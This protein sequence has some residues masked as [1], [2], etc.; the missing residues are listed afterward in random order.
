MKH[1]LLILSTLISLNLSA[2]DSNY[3]R[4]DPHH[5]PF[6]ESINQFLTPVF[7]EGR[8]QI[9]KL[10]P[11]QHYLDIPNA[12]RKH[13][14]V[15][16]NGDWKVI[17]PA[18]LTNSQEPD[19]KILHMISKINK[20]YINQHLETIIKK[21]SRRSGAPGNQEIVTYIENHLK[22]HSFQ[23]TKN[24]FSPGLCNIY[25]IIPGEIDEYVLIEA[26]LDSVGHAN[27]GADDNASG[28]ASLLEL[29]RLLSDKSYK[30]GLIIFA[31]NGEESGLL[32]SK[33]FVKKAATSGL[34]SK[35]KFVINMDMIAY[36]KNKIVDIE[37]DKRFE[38][39]AKWMSSLVN[40]YTSLKPLITMPAWGSD[41]V[42]FIRKGV[43]GIL[44]IEHWKTKTPCYHRSCDKIDTLNLPYMLEITKLNLAAALIKLKN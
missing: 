30:R 43:P 15:I 7:N 11:N 41:H 39:L 19:P 16:K 8:M 35:I 23:T 28:T 20:S 1:L 29:A 40:T 33:T 6:N 21:Y 31:T 44:T 3:Y 17:K 36:N 34:L 18:Q 13:L 37:T 4:F 2:T 10:K 12:L 25:G 32:G 5:G 9:Y 14:T 42:P 38:S 22:D 27:A 26:H 24:C